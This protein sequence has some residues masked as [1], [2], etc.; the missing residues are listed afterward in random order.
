[1]RLRSVWSTA[2]GTIFQSC[3]NIP[4]VNLLGSSDSIKPKLSFPPRPQLI[5]WLCNASLDGLSLK[6]T[7]RGTRTQRQVTNR[8]GGDGILIDKNHVDRFYEIRHYRC[9]QVQQSK[10]LRRRDKI[11]GRRI[12]PWRERAICL[13]SLFIMEKR[14]RQWS[15]VTL[16]SSAVA[17][18]YDTR[19]PQL[20]RQNAVSK[21]TLAITV[22]S[23]LSLLSVSPSFKLIPPFL[24]QPRNPDPV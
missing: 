10:I 15:L 19:L 9:R 11:H 2:E 18:R 12:D 1:M 13:S 16:T 14:I 24:V 5:E 3:C 7:A 4:E 17:L 6:M 8:Y 21:L 20:K 22:I 23:Y